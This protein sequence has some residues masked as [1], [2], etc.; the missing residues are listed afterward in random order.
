MAENNKNNG[1]NKRPRRGMPQ[2]PKLPRGDSFWVN[3]ATSIVLLLLLAG[4]YS[5]FMGASGQK[6]ENISLSQLAQDIG[7]G[8]VATIQVDGDD[9]HVSYTDESQKQSK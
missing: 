6:P 3:L 1:G 8:K 9:L 7:A 5:Y 2:I 4:A